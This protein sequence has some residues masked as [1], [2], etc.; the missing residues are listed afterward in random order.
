MIGWPR[1]NS[2]LLRERAPWYSAR[3]KLKMILFLLTVCGALQLTPARA[4]EVD[5]S[6]VQRQLTEREM[7]IE[8]LSTEE[9]LK[10]RGAQQK[11]AE[12]PAVKA[13]LEKRNQAILEF[14]AA[15]RA[16]SIKAD[17]SVEPILDRIAAASQP[18][19]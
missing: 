4:E 1:A 19:F 16:A 7:K 8:K 3:M 6:D 11:A 2:R 13:A 9:Q 12:D 17:P 5:G 14:R 18:G 15:L 10:L